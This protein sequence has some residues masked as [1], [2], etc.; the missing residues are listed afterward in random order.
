MEGGGG[1][2]SELYSSSKRLSLKIRDALERLERLD[3]TSTSSSSLSSS[4]AVVAGSSDDQSTL[5]RRDINQIQSLCAEMDRLWRSI[6]SKPQRDIWKSYES[7]IEPMCNNVVLELFL[8]MME[9]RKECGAEETTHVLRK[10]LGDVIY[11]EI[12][13]TR[14]IKC[15]INIGLEFWV[16]LKTKKVEQVSEEAESFRASLDRYTSRHQKRVQEAQERAEL[17][18]RPS[19]DAHVLRIFDEESQAA[20]SVRR[21]SRLLEDSFATGVAILSKYSEQRDHLK[22][23]QRKALDV[24]NTLGLSNSL[25][26]LIERRSRFD[27]WIKY[28]GM[29]VTII[30]VVMFWRWTR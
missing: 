15:L 8:L 21:S 26:R 20:E 13:P 22:R 25:L 10:I 19:G 9:L 24:L 6:P 27:K 11:V 2:L 23:A 5:I 28:A 4:S 30:I 17:F 29:T 14:G 7:V 12:G 16:P 3:F 1:N 18:R